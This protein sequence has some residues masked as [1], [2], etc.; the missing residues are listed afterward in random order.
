MDHFHYYLEQFLTK[1]SC[2]RYQAFVCKPKTFKVG[3]TTYRYFIHPYNATWRSE[4]AVEIPIALDYLRRYFSKNILEVGNVLSHYL[5]STHHIVIDKYE[6]APDVL[7]LDAIEYKTDIC[8]DLIVSISTLEHVGF[9]EP[10][11]DEGKFKQAIDHLLTLL[12]P[13]GVML[14]T[15]PIGYNPAVHDYL[16]QMPQAH[17]RVAYLKRITKS[18]IWQ[19]TTWSEVKN[20]KYASPFPMAN[21]LA[22]CMFSN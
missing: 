16:E 5:D 7:N 20:V 9:D 1:L 14:I 2:L 17:S 18:N 19:Q 10:I 3:E 15:V 4:R 21:G 11:K 6:Q 12:A 8:F 13:N 22:I